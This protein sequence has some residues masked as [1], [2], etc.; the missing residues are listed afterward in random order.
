[1]P[2]QK[3]VNYANKLVNL[4]G[5][6]SLCVYIFIYV[7]IYVISVLRCSVSLS[8]PNI[9]T[10]TSVADAGKPVTFLFTALT[11]TL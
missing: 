9:V 11:N 7:N 2:E 8:M 3:S 4:S 1:M 5:Q 6:W 10:C